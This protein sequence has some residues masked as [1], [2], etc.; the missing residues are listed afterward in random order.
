MQK[1]RRRAHVLRR[2]ESARSEI[3]LEHEFVK[4]GGKRSD[5]HRLARPPTPPPRSY[6]GSCQHAELPTNE[7]TQLFFRVALTS[8]KSASSTCC[9][10][11][12]P[13]S[14]S[15]PSGASRPMHPSTAMS[16]SAVAPG[17]RAMDAKAVQR[18]P[19]ERVGDAPA[20]AAD[21]WNVAVPGTRRW[22]VASGGGERKDKERERKSGRL[23]GEE[24][25]STMGARKWQHH[26]NKVDAAADCAVFFPAR[27]CRCP[28]R[29]VL[30]PMR[31]AALRARRHL[32]PP[33]PCALA[34]RRLTTRR[35]A[36]GLARRLCGSPAH[37]HLVE[38]R[39]HLPR[40]RARGAYAVSPQLPHQGSAHLGPARAASVGR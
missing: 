20:T 31:V 40:T 27:H 32:H 26:K 5:A 14:Y 33:W 8:D 30:G 28:G 25:M 2:R 9:R 39:Y 1:A 3:A 21:V 22:R 4:R 23:C 34:A 11:R 38:R 18:P 10:V 16:T 17:R 13:F 12:V 35:L 6:S 15:V 24:R 29:L 19:T 37:P 36:L 7:E